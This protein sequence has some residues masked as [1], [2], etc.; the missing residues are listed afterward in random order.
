[1]NR[2]TLQT[3]TLLATTLRRQL[4]KSA[5]GAIELESTTDKAVRAIRRD[6]HSMRHDAERRAVL[7][8]SG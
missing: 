1:M 5:P 7:T 6:R 3:V 8:A 2:R 4:A